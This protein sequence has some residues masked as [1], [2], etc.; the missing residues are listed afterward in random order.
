MLRNFGTKL[1]LTTKATLVTIAIVIALATALA[2]ASISEV[3]RWIAL[4]AVE[5]QASSLRIAAMV[6][7][8]RYPALQVTFNASNN[9]DRLVI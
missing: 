3:Q 1:N 6:L 7:A 8:D 4:Q 5:R 9:V 2:Y